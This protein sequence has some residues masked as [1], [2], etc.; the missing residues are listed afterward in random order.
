V[1][2]AARG[3]KFRHATIVLIGGPMTLDD[4]ST[5]DSRQPLDGDP[6][7]SITRKTLATSWLWWSAAF[8]VADPLLDAAGED[9]F[10]LLIGDRSITDLRSDGTLRRTRLGSLLVGGTTTIELVRTAMGEPLLDGYAEVTTLR[11]SNNASLGT[12]G[13]RI[14]RPAKR[15]RVLDGNEYYLSHAGP[16]IRPAVI[17][18]TSDSIIGGRFEALE[19]RRLFSDDVVLVLPHTHRADSFLRDYIQW[20]H[21]GRQDEETWMRRMTEVRGHIDRVKAGITSDEPLPSVATAASGPSARDPIHYA[22]SLPV[23]AEFRVTGLVE[24]GE[25]RDPADLEAAR[26]LLQSR[27][28]LKIGI[29]DLVRNP[30]LRQT[31]LEPTAVSPKPSGVAAVPPGATQRGARRLAQNLDAAA[32]KATALKAV[33][34][35]L[36]PLRALGWAATRPDELSLALSEPLH[37][38]PSGDAFPLVLLQII[39]TKRQ[40]T[41]TAWT[42]IYNHVDIKSYV[43][44]R[45]ERLERIAEP[46]PCELSGMRPLIWRGAGGWADDVDWAS[47]ARALADRTEPWAATFSDLCDECIRV[48]RRRFLLG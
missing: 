40:T 25:W 37:R 5:I 33:S 4:G 38:W 45:R 47:R 29:W 41:I 12:V 27:F 13:V 8:S 3:A 15:W 46:D 1:T 2:S 32:T 10:A 23:A 34:R 35:Q 22:S 43:L 20:G 39:I 28:D 24:G 6:T 17:V 36:K 42:S 44:A 18:D 16:A 21:E 30:V 26:S 7:S 11:G 14:S 31:L 19:Q 48:Q 9:A